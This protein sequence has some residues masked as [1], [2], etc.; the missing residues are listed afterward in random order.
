MNLI[1]WKL[2]TPAQGGTDKVNR[3]MI[4]W[5]KMFVKYQVLRD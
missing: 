3:Q 4:V 2:N 5:K 1:K